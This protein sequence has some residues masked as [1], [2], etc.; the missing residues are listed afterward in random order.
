MGRQAIDWDRF[1]GD[2]AARVLKIALRIVGRLDDAEDVAQEVFQ[3][4]FRVERESGL[5]DPTGM[6]VRLATVRSLDRL[7]RRRA[8]PDTIALRDGDRV[9][10]IGPPEHAQATELAEW[11]RAAVAALPARQ[12]EVFALVS[13]EQLPRDEAAKLL[14][15]TPEAVSTALAKARKELALNLDRRSGRQP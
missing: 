1:V 3:E 14:G 7:R 13:M 4:C 12:A 15:I 11:L 9:T 10:A 8:R 6:A 5:R 2:H